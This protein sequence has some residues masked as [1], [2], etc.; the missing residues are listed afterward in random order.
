MWALLTGA[1]IYT[2]TRQS[3]ARIPIAALIISLIGL[4]AF[5]LPA[6]YGTVAL[7]G[8][9]V[10]AAMAAAINAKSRHFEFAA[11]VLGI[12]YTLYNFTWL[13][14]SING[15]ISIVPIINGLAAIYFFW[16]ALRKNAQHKTFH[17]ILA[18]CQLTTLAMT[19]LHLLAGSIPATENIASNWWHIFATNRIYD[20]QLLLVI[21]ASRFRVHAKKDPKAWRKKVASKK[22]WKITDFFRFDS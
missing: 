17:L 12:L 9:I 8:A 13:F 2:V 18:V 11:F 7:Y 22:R 20:A 3:R 1:L 21:I 15:A 19:Y 5:A 6:D 10:I 4:W 14:S 16:Q